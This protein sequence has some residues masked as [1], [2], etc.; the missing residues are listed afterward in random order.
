MARIGVI[1]LL[2]IVSAF[3]QVAMAAEL[4]LA[5]VAG[6]WVTEQGGYRITLKI[7]AKDGASE[8]TS[9]FAALGVS[10]VERGVASVVGGVLVIRILDED[11]FTHEVGERRYRIV[12]AAADHLDVIWD[13][14]VVRVRLS[15]LRR[16]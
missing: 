5:D 8:L 14:P 4:A 9:A 7:H 10:N 11:D 12:E 1:F 3:A 2:L 6:T 16:G 13:G 15:C